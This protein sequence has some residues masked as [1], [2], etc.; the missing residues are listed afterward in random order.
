MKVKEIKLAA[1]HQAL[2]PLIRQ[3]WSPRAFADRPIAPVQMEE[4]IEAARWAASAN[5]EQPWQYVYAFRGTPG[6]EQLWEC[7]VPGN[8]AWADRAAVLLVALQRN[9]FAKSGQANPWATH[10]LGLANAQLLLQAQ[11]RDIYGHML[12]GFVPDKVRTLLQLS[13]DQGPVCMMALGYLGDAEQLAEPFRSRE[14]AP[15]QRLALTTISRVL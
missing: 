1:S 5:N 13:A 10:D 9:S 15:R 12:A 8:Q 6:F 2:H 7:L 3:R 4:L 14:L 11:Y